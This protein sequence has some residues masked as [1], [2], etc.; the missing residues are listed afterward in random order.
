MKRFS[1]LFFFLMSA[2]PLFSLLGQ[3]FMGSANFFVGLPQG[4]FKDNVE[5]AGVGL[6]ANIGYAPREVP[7]MVGLE[8]GF[9]NYG[10][11]RRREPFS[12]TIPDV[13]VDVESSNNFALGHLLLRLQPN[14]G[15]IRPYLEGAAG[16][17][18]LFTSTSIKNIGGEGEEIASSTN[19]D[20]ITFSLGG[21]GGVLIR[22]W[23]KD[24]DDDDEENPL[25]AAMIDLRL[26]YLSGGEAEYLKEGSIRRENGRV[27]YDV[28]RSKTDLLSV[29]IGVSVTF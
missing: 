6:T 21:G 18:Y 4:P 9:M 1:F 14:T 2:V 26:R 20:D 23:Q 19:L 7:F 3:E 24:Q 12:T 29:Q 27:V 16:F 17:H 25:S 13:T 22:V 5:N 11:D 10:T 15:S 28:K 8:F